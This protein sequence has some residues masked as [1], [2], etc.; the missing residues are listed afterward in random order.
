MKGQARPLRPD[1]LRPGSG[2]DQAV[3]PLG[4]STSAARVEGGCCRERPGP[5]GA[6]ILL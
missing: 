2:E 1:V 5:S 3:P 4:R 6:W